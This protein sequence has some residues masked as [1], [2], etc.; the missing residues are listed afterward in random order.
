LESYLH[1]EPAHA[2]PLIRSYVNPHKGISARYISSMVAELMGFAGLAH[3]AHALRHTA[4]TDMLRGGAHLRD[5][6]FA[7]G[8]S[9]LHTT[10]RYLPWIVGDLRAAMG[11]RSY[12]FGRESEE[13]VK[14]T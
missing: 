9:T 13:G 4:A 10:Q 11:G 2:G 1:D 7:L 6:Q 8:H 12:R 5:V 3:T 14:A